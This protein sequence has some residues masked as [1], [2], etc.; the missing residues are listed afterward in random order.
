MPENIVEDD[1]KNE[2]EERTPFPWL[3]LLMLVIS[4]A[5]YSIMSRHNV[6]FGPLVPAI[7]TVA[8]LIMLLYACR[9]L[10]TK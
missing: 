2:E 7:N 6:S 9:Q 4:V 1:E 3:S 8:V 5:G 10:S